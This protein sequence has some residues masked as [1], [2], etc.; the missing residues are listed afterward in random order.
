VTTVN[1]AL[2]E[3]LLTYLLSLG[4]SDSESE[5]LRQS[6][7]MC[8]SLRHIFVEVGLLKKSTFVTCLLLLVQTEM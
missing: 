6:E 7:K 3:H 5:S 2:E 4:L 8:P 1:C